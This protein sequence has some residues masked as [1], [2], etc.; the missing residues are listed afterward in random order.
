VV[1]EVGVD[2]DDD[3]DVWR[4]LRGTELVAEIHIE[5]A[6]QPWLIGRLRP[7]PAY[8]EVAPLFDELRA[9]LRADP[10]DSEAVRRVNDRVHEAVR[11]VAPHGPVAEFW[12]LP[13][14]DQV[15]FRFSDEPFDRDD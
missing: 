13:H 2:Q 15:W 1:R 3:D 8:A 10:R 6:D 5:D 7:G 14:G 11:M 9:L 4:L 12:L